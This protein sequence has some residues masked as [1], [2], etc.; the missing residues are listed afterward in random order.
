MSALAGHLAQDLDIRLNTR[1]RQVRKVAKGSVLID[2]NGH[3]ADGFDALVVAIPPAQGAD[4]LD[5]VTPLA[6]RLTAVNMAPCWA[7]M[8]AFAKPVDLPFDGAFVHDS[9][10]AW[11]ARNSSKPQRQHGECWVLHATAAWSSANLS[12]RSEAVVCHLTR[13]FSAAAGVNLPDPVFS[14]AHRWRYAQAR[15]PLTA[16][17]LWDRRSGVGVCGDWCCGSRVEGAY[18][19]GAAM[20]G[21]ILTDAPD[22]NWSVSP[23]S[24]E[25]IDT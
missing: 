12:M 11:A 1:I 25:T 7:V 19:S 23:V 10:I 8:L 13:S 24:W 15:K 16:G 21:R 9:E 14:S 22:Q 6:H 3:A 5:G 18:L 17:A 4:L 20:A 2:E